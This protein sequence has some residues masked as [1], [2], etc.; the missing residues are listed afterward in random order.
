[1]NLPNAI[2]V[3]R[4]FLTAVFVAAVGFRTTTGF[5]IALITFS[6]AAATDWLDGYLARKLGMVTPLGKLL[7]PLA[8]KILVCAAFVYFS[9]Q[10]V[11]GYHCPVWVSS[12]IIAREF[13]VTGL[14]QIAVEAG[15]VLAAD[16]L[17]KWK[18]TFQLT[19]CITGLVW[20]TFSSMSDPGSI[21]GMLRDWAHPKAW[22]MP[23]SLWTAVALTM[24]SGTN[25]VWGSRKL[26]VQS[27]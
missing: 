7:D 2:T 10:P 23:V 22:L 6:V 24:I 26:L 3:S 19:F 12:L 27:K 17:G 11:G 25:Y 18:T 9:A 14:R 1:M 8:D 13:L 20:L 16:R 4:L 5:T 15:Q 21:G